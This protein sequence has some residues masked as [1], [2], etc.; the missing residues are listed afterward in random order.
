M[1]E[2]E[3]R[4]DGFHACWMYDVLRIL[5]LKLV[6]RFGHRDGFQELFVNK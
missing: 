2:S 1:S 5:G 3:G 4:G 6:N